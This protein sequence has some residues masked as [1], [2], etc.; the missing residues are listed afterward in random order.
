MK[1]V[2]I[3]GG[4]VSGLT[5][6]VYGRLN[7]YDTE[8]FEKHS[9]AGGECT[10]W[11]RKDYYFD[12]CIHWLLG[13][14]NNSN[15]NA[16][17]RET[18]ALSDSVNII[19]LDY[20]YTYE[21]D[22][23]VVYLYRDV[24]KLRNHLKDLSPEDSE[25]ID[26]M[27]NG[28]IGMKSMQMPTKKPFDMM[29]VIDIFG[30]IFGMFSAMKYVKE[31]DKYSLEDFADGFKSRLIGNSFKALIPKEH[32]CTALITTIAS[33][34]DGDAGWP[35]GGSLKFAQRIEEKYK[36]LGGKI[37]YN[38]EID[39][40]W[41]E[42]GIAKGI[43]LKDGT[44]VQ[45]DYVISSADGHKTLY[46]MLD[47]KYLNDNFRA[48]YSD[49]ETYPLYITTQVSMGVNCDLSRYPHTRIIDIPEGYENGGKINYSIGFRNYE[50]DKTLMP[51]GK[52]AL[53]VVNETDYDW[54]SE[55]YKDK[56]QYLIEKEKLA[57]I[58]KS[59]AV[60]Y[61]PEI[62]DKIEVIDVATPMTYVRYCNA[63][64][65][66]WMTSIPTPKSKIR[67]LPAKL[68]GL[69]NFSLAGQWI[70]PP[71]G[72]PTAVTTGKFAI[73]R[74]CKEDKKKFKTK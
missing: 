41:I 46:E 1:K 37:H 51:E 27:C 10:G 26:K 47:G 34:A 71:G 36:S 31:F 57:E 70:M 18:G 8:I 45:G 25:R 42:D 24:E 56:K 35:E 4:G 5:A 30:M 67:F 55:K 63:W 12:G 23:K 52:T 69:K 7:G 3:I 33:M 32:K 54:W 48:M 43:I 13:S 15:L 62:K 49:L 2:L 38:T 17:W 40:I 68:E 28:I 73:Q 59:Y 22:G 53:I 16:L 66:A 60:K 61:Y 50:F 11:K 72:L 21:A 14:K 19:N 64:R 6:G 58:V 9:V 20:F 74:L 65:G 44:K 29:N 39:K